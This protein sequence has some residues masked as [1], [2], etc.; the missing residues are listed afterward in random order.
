MSFP[1]S[2]KNLPKQIF[3]N[4]EYVES[5][6]SK[7]LTL[8]NPADGSRIADD[9]ALAG[10][11][12]VDAAVAA[13]EKAFPAWKKITASERRNIMTKFAD[14]VEKH[15]TEIAE[16]SRISLGAPYKAFG[17]FEVGLCAEVSF[18]R[19]SSFI[20]FDSCCHFV[21]NCGTIGH[22]LIIFSHRH[23]ATTL[24]ILTNSVESRGRKT[25]ASSRLFATSRWVSPLA[26]C[27]GTAQSAQLDSRPP[28]LSLP[29]TASS[30]SLQKRHL[31]LPSPSV[32]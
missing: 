6:N 23:S 32:P 12:D 26:W 24:A 15:S 2:S 9:V 19:L 13:A 5:K 30:S 11:Q 21:V 14:L 22:M 7:K 1:W 8:D 29:E 27:H 20:L 10:E 16:L 25:T 3:I 17:A 18:F 4:N 31:S 28:L